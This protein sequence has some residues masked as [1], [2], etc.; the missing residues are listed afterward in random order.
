MEKSHKNLNLCEITFDS[1]N[2]FLIWLW[3]QSN[4]T[5]KQFTLNLVSAE[6]H[7]RN[8]RA[9]TTSEFSSISLWT[10]DWSESDFSTSIDEGNKGVKSTTF[11]PW[12]ARRP[13]P[14]SRI[15]PLP[16]R[17]GPLWLPNQVG[18]VAR[19]ETTVFGGRP[20]PRRVEALSLIVSIVFRRRPGP[21]RILETGSFWLCWLI[22]VGLFWF[23]FKRDRIFF[24]R[25]MGCGGFFM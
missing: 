23:H 14:W 5:L 8:F 13:R 19:L 6:S 25:I 15:R 18:K 22:Y 21:R 4:T 17:I 3:R 9:L 16:W 11:N 1:S 10:F 20:R 2:L 12:F 24:S 7:S